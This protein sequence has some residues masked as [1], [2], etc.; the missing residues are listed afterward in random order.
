MT[1]KES[2]EKGERERGYGVWKGDLY[3]VGDL[4]GGKRAQRGWEEG[5]LEEMG[6]GVEEVVRGL[7]VWRGGDGGT[8][9]FGGKLPWELNAS[10][11]N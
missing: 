1:G 10:H 6:R 4:L 9:I 8:E 7:L 11:S 2:L 3:G 5:C